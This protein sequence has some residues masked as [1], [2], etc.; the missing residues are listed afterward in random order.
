MCSL[1]RIA[2]EKWRAERASTPSDLPPVYADVVV[3]GEVWSKN[4][5]GVKREEGPEKKQC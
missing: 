2:G 3:M 5:A 4:D 1:R